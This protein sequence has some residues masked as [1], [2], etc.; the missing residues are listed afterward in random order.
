MTL[1]AQIGH[2]VAWTALSNVAVKS[3][4]VFYLVLLLTHLSVYEFGLVELALSTVGLLSLLSLGGM[5]PVLIADLVR[6]KRADQYELMRQMISSYLGLRLVLAVCTT[7][8]LIFGTWFL[9]DR[10]ENDTTTLLYVLA[11]IFLVSPW[12]SL[13]LITLTASQNFRTLAQFRIGEDLIKL[14]VTALAL[15][16]LSWPPLAVIV[17]YVLTDYFSTSIFWFWSRRSR[18]K[19][20]DYHVF[21]IDI[22][23]PNRV[24]ERHMQWGIWF[25][26]LG[27]LSIHVKPWIIQVVLGTQAV[28]LY[29]TAIGLY[30]NI[31]SLMPLSAVLEPI[32]PAYKHRPEIV[33]KLINAAIKY[34]LLVLG[35]VTSV[36]LLLL[37]YIISWM[38]PHYL[39]A[40]PLLT[41][42]A[43]CLIPESLS[44]VYEIFFNA[45]QLQRDLFFSNVVRLMLVI[46]V[47]P[48]AL[49]TFGIY[50]VAVE[51]F[52]TQMWYLV[53]RYRGV[54]KYVPSYQL[55]LSSLWRITEADIMVGQFIKRKL[56]L[57]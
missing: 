48:I 49:F 17:G 4:G 21:T 18:L 11:V 2:G 5:Q 43:I 40:M 52:M 15:F 42:L 45:F 31:V 50:G 44:R 55:Q 26:A 57:R 20:F 36:A 27:V 8:I 41:V 10:L 9:S 54:A 29:A 51:V 56:R 12:R 22:L 3:I 30:Q 35:C 23:K 53:S 38:V 14:F 24:L 28:G 19:F 1:V 39:V 34:Q 33:T 47:L 32:L 6:Y 46:G 13:L 25:G 37:P 16:W 7:G